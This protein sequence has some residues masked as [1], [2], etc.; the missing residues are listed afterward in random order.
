[1]NSLTDNVNAGKV[2][3]EERAISVKA[4]SGGIQIMSAKVNITYCFNHA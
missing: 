1:M 4:I 3:E 2:S